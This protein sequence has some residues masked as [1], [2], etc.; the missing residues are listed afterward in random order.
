MNRWGS[1]IRLV[2][3]GFYIGCSIVLGVTMGLW[4]DSKL[5][6]QPILVIAGLFFGLF[7][8]GY[9]VY[10]MLIPLL[11]KDEKGEN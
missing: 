9:G 6:T 4:L 10:R 7:L 8:A 1:A 5:N 11:N 3:V 2:G